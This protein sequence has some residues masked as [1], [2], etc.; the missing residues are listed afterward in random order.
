VVLLIELMVWSVKDS[1]VSQMMSTVISLGRVHIV[2]MMHVWVVVVMVVLSWSTL[3]GKLECMI[4]SVMVCLIMIANPVVWVVLTIAITVSPLVVSIRTKVEPM[5]CISVVLC[6]GHSKLCRSHL[7]RNTELGWV[8]RMMRIFM[9]QVVVCLMSDW[10]V[11]MEVKF[12][13][14]RLNWMLAM[15]TMCITPVMIVSWS[16]VMIF[17]Q[18]LDHVSL[19]CIYRVGADL[20]FREVFGDRDVIFL[21]AILLHQFLC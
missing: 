17:I 5:L 19:I 16:I 10:V 8:V 2:V 14:R 3:G 15:V 20:F 4:V 18:E 12:V 11:V 13:V 21:L 7:C 9:S 6:M 1:M